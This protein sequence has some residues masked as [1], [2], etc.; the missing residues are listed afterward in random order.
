MQRGLGG[1][2]VG[3]AFHQLRRHA[4]RQIRRQSQL[5]ELEVRR[6]EIR[7][8]MPGE[9]RQGVARLVQRLVERR[10]CPFQL[11]ERGVLRENVGLRDGAEIKLAAHHRERFA[12]ECDDPFGGGD[13]RPQARLLDR[14]GHHVRREGQI[15]RIELEAALFRLRR[16]RLHLPSVQTE[17]V[18]HVAHGDLRGIEIEQGRPGRERRR[19]HAHCVLLPLR[20]EPR[21]RRR[22]NNCRAAR[23]CFPALGAAP[24][25]R[26]ARPG[27]RARPPPPG[28]RVPRTRTASTSCAARPPRRGIAGR[29]RPPPA[30]TRSTRRAAPRCNAATAGGAGRW[31]LGPTHAASADANPATAAAR[32]QAAGLIRPPPAADPPATRALSRIAAPAR[33]APAVSARARAACRPPRPAPAAAAPAIRCPSTWRPG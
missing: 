29:P 11:R 16:E 8:Q 24:L 22:E 17:N 27:W 13:L 33:A 30:P 9:P 25:G 1:A 31:K 6:R 14:R 3:T 21:L 23:R 32:A 28:H 18:G 7:R 26:T 10:Q 20:I 12:L 4:E 2:H 5:L 19:Q 15:G